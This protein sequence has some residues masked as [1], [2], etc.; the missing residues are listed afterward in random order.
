MGSSGGTNGRGRN[1]TLGSL[2][3]TVANGVDDGVKSSGA[4]SSDSL[5]VN[6][7]VDYFSIRRETEEAAE[8][9][10]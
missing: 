3:G 1:E 6:G 10:Y 7:V 2:D 5:R 4:V 8:E 9:M